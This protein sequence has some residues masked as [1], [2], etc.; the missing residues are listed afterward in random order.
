MLQF[1]LDDHRVAAPTVAVDDLLVGQHRIAFLAPVDRRFLF[2]G[3]APFEKQQEEPLRPAIVFRMAGRHFPFPVVGQAEFLLLPAHVADIAPRPVGRMNLVLDR[4]I[5]RRH[6]ERIPTHRMQDI[7]SPHLL[8]TSHY[9][10]NGI[11]AH[12]AHVQGSRRVRK[13]LEHVVLGFGPI[14]LGMESAGIGPALLPLGFNLAGD[15]F[16]V[17]RHPPQTKKPRSWRGHG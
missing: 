5:F 2:I 16:L 13:H 17:H 14:H 12:M 9:V 1:L 6:A 3:Q 7:V 4:G 11:I 15:V 8:E 10:P